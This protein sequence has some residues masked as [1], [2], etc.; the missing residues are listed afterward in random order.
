MVTKISVA[1]KWWN[2]GANQDAEKEQGL[3]DV[4]DLGRPQEVGAFSSAGATL[5]SPVTRV[6]L[7]CLVDGSDSRGWHRNWRCTCTW[8]RR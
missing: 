6:R 8:R 2:G 1:S 3:C 5:A 7:L 4:F